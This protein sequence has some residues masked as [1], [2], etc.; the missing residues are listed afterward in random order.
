[1]TRKG[2][3]HKIHKQNGKLHR[4]WWDGSLRAIIWIYAVCKCQLDD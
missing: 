4:S 2:V 3:F 1:L